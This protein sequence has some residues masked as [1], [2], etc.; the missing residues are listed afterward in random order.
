MDEGETAGEIGL[1]QVEAPLQRL[2][3]RHDHVIMIGPRL[4]AGGEAQGLL[5]APADAVAHH[6][7]AELLGDGE[8]DAG[9]KAILFAC[10]RSGAAIGLERESLHAGA[11]SAPGA[12]TIAAALEPLDLRRPP[13]PP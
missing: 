11:A 7:A 5:Q 10:G 13:A 6:R 9:A 4:K 2:P 3:L 12:L 8:A 1:K